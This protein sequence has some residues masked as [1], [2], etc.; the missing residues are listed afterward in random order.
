[1]VITHQPTT[2]E[3]QQYPRFVEHIPAAVFQD[4]SYL[5]RFARGADELDAVLKLRFEVFNLELN[6]GLESSYHTWR[7]E[8]EF[9]A[10]CHHLMVLDQTTG[11]V[12][13]TYRM[14]TQE[15]AG[16]GRGF[17]SAAEF[18]L[19][20]FSPEVLNA[21]VEL[22]RACVS[23][24]HRNIRVLLLLWRGLAAYLAHNQKRYLFG[25]CSLTSQDPMEGKRVMNYL[26]AH[27][28]VD[29]SVRVLPQPGFECYGEDLAA[30][31]RTDVKIPKLMKLYLM[32]G[33]KLCGPP[34]IDR[35]FKTIDYL[36]L[37]DVHKLEEKT[38]RYFFR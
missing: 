11:A 10:H 16:D 28:H 32:Y 35:Q 8:D 25:C 26:A 18:D 29:P 38:Y 15:M 2:V 3:R 17:Y 19:S 33:A 5:L 13:G 36:G 1:M 6:E 21:G 34:A 23:K 12:V 24:E 37:I 31:D 9:D 7:D 4:G 20:G 14:Q 27:G 30:D 22:G